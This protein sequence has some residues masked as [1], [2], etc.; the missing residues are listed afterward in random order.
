MTTLDDSLNLRPTGV[1]GRWEHPRLLALLFILA[2]GSS[3]N[4]V[5]N[6]DLPNSDLWKGGTLLGEE[7][8]A[9]GGVGAFGPGG[10]S[11]EQAKA[12]G[13][14]EQIVH[15]ACG[16]KQHDHDAEGIRQCM[17]YEMKYTMWS[18]YGCG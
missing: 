3:V 14:I 7:A 18:A 17:A 10:E 13:R 8:A 9:V 2:L 5:V 12:C 16:L 11:W 4:A 6:G 15:T 1:L